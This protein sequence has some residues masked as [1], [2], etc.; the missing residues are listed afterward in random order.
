M[1][2][3]RWSPASTCL[4]CCVSSE[5]PAVNTPCCVF[6]CRV[7]L[8]LDSRMFY[9]NGGM[10]QN[11]DYTA[12]LVRHL[13]WL[14]Q[15]CSHMLST[16]MACRCKLCRSLP[17]VWCSAVGSQD[18]LQE[19]ADRAARALDCWQ[20]ARLTVQR[21]ARHDDANIMCA[22]LS[23]MSCSASDSVQ[24]CTSSALSNSVTSSSH[25]LHPRQPRPSQLLSTPAGC[26]M[27]PR[28]LS[29]YGSHRCG[30]HTHDFVGARLPTRMVAGVQNLAC[31][32]HADRHGLH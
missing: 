11:A 31:I 24:G 9:S 18:P 2:R 25:P 1:Q 8:N 15:T 10:F 19:N 7:Q 3:R 20:H 32:M 14:P 23:C 13:T 21:S 6:L 4:R 17:A 12:A 26:M 28:P 5:H 30:T 22:L 16:A 29:R 27:L